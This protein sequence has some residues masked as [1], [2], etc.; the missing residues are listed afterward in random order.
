MSTLITALLSALSSAAL[1]VFARLISRAMF[2]K[3]LEQ[4]ILS[5][6]QRLADKTDSQLLDQVAVIVRAE[7]EK[8]PVAPDSAP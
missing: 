8:K 6:V 3:L 4:L 7:L 2:E 5:G 1:S